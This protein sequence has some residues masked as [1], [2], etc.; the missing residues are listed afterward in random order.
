MTT[1]NRRY[2]G[3]ELKSGG[4]KGGE[5]GG[6]KKGGKEGTGAG[7]I[8]SMLQGAA[9]GRMGGQGRGG[10]GKVSYLAYSLAGSKTKTKNKEC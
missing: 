2:G 1:H 6:G 7:S 4:G 9:D 8:W 10:L 3:R 5:R